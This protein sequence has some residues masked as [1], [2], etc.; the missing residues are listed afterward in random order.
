[1]AIG[2]CKMLINPPSEHVLQRELQDSRILSRADLTERVRAERVKT[3]LG[4]LIRR[5]EAVQDV[6]RL[7][8]KLHA[9]AFTHLELPCDR[10]IEFPERRSLNTRFAQIAVGSHGR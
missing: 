8:S 3:C 4:R 7:R 5:N 9:L 1:M 2:K 6:V 10:H